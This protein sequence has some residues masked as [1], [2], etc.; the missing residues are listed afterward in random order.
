MSIEETLGTLMKQ[1][2]DVRRELACIEFE[3]GEMA[4]H[5]QAIADGLRASPPT[6][7]RPHEYRHAD[8]RVARLI[9]ETGNRISEHATLLAKK[10]QLEVSLRKAGLGD[11]IGE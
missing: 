10:S 8:S 1:Y 11:L 6:L 2:L 5:L 3:L 7:P 9:S 4:D